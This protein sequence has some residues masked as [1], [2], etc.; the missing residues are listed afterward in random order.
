PRTR[1]ERENA[2]A[3]GEAGTPLTTEELR[4]RF[5][6]LTRV[7]Y[8]TG[9]PPSRLER[10]VFPYIAPDIVFFDPLVRTRGARI[11]RI[12]RLGF[13]CLARFDFDIFQMDVKRTAQGGRV[14]VDGVMNL[15]NLIIYTYP[16][17]TILAID[18]VFTEG[19]RSFAITRLEEMWSLGD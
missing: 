12:G 19:G 18:F 14:L 3:T 15:R 4:E 17:R 7:M 5:A 13:H 2:V 10:E 9:V 8:D 6:T 16:L 1:R 11:F